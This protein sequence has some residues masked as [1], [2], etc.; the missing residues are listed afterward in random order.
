MENETQRD[1]TPEEEAAMKATESFVRQPVLAPP[2]W[3]DTLADEHQFNERRYNSLHDRVKALEGRGSFLP[4]IDEE[5]VMF[6]LTGAY[7][8]FAYVLPAVFRLFEKNAA[9]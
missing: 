9:E 6:W 4:N 3:I 8:L 2:D 7:V 5:N 1:W